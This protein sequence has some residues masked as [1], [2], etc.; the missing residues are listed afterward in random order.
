[1]S[2]LFNKTC[3]LEIRR[4]LHGN[5]EDFQKPFVE[6]RRKNGLYTINAIQ[7]PVEH[8]TVIGERWFERDTGKYVR[9]GLNALGLTMDK[10]VNQHGFADSIK[11]DRDWKI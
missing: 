1:M 5:P 8:E 3:G 11:L 10:M 9:I 6:L 4:V 2:R 7:W